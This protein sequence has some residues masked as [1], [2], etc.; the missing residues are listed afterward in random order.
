MSNTVYVNNLTALGGSGTINV[1]SGTAIKGDGGAIM[2]PGLVTQV[3]F[4]YMNP[5]RLSLRGDSLNIIPGTEMDFRCFR[6]TSKILLTAT[7]SSNAPHVTSFG[8][9]VDGSPLWD[10][11]GNSNSN[12]AV[13]TTY[14]RWTTTAP[15]TTGYLW[16]G[17]TTATAQTTSR[18]T[19]SA[20]Q[21][22]MNM[23]TIQYLYTPGDGGLRTYALGASTSWGGQGGYT[24][25]INDRWS[26]DMRSISTFSAMELSQT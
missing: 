26:Y 10:A 15:P 9:M 16:Y 18:N 24:L 19:N 20:G 17:G 11:T 14:Y 8:F 22:T 3:K 1:K 7:I 6:G 25:I 21:D 13:A 12:G 4:K 2:T 23:V 5:S